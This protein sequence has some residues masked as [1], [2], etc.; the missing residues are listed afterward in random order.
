[1]ASLLAEFHYFS[2]CNLRGQN[3]TLLWGLVLATPL[4]ASFRSQPQVSI[5][6]LNII[7]IQFKVSGNALVCL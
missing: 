4:I 6:N 5:K 7:I 3:E 1:M 2:V